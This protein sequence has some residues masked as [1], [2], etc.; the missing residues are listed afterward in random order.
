MES[1]LVTIQVSFECIGVDYAFAKH[2][3]ILLGLRHCFNT[4]IF[5][6]THNVIRFEPFGLTHTRGQW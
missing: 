2:H 4:A 6:L 1:G 3:F 5:G